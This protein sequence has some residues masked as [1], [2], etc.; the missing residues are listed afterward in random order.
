MGKLAQLND[1][2]AQLSVTKNDTVM[3]LADLPSMMK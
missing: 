3:D 1:K 2:H